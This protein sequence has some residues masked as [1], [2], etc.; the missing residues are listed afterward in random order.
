MPYHS[1]YCYIGHLRNVEE[2]QM[3]MQMPYSALHWPGPGWHKKEGGASLIPKGT[4]RGRITSSV[5]PIRFGP[6]TQPCRSAGCALVRRWLASI[7]NLKFGLVGTVECFENFCPVTLATVLVLY[8][9]LLSLFV[10]F[11]T[12]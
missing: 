12:K 7:P 6:T 4:D 5:A 9:P 3:P 11:L 2:V 10:L 1:R 8:C